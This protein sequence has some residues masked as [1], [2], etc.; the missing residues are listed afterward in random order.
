MGAADDVRAGFEEAVAAFVA[1][2]G[3]R[4]LEAAT[5]SGWTTK[6]MV[7]HAAFWLETVPPFVTGAFRDR[8]EAFDLTFPSGFRPADDGSWP[9]ADVHNEREAQW[10]REQSASAV[11]GRLDDAIAQLRSFLT[12]VTDDEATAHRDYFRDIAGHLDA[13]RTSEL[14]G[15]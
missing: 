1:A 6:E 14:A 15:P 2:L 5:P 4:D 9:S 7:A 8:P 13:H 10:A 12:T 3:E 11:R